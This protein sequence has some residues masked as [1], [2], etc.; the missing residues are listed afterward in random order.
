MEVA[1]ALLLLRDPRREPLCVSVVVKCKYLSNS[2]EF[3][4]VDW[5]CWVVE[6]GEGKME[7][8]LFVCFS[9]FQ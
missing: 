5:F 9:A 4:F 8:V 3:Y 2:M 7:R 1:E 6:N